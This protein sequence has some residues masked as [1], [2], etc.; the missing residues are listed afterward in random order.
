MGIFQVELKQVKAEMLEIEDQC[1]GFVIKVKVSIEGREYEEL[2][3]M[4]NF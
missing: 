4:I 2:N 1:F 3:S